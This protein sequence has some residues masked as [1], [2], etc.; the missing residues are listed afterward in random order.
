[1]FLG[2]IEW[3]QLSLPFLSSNVTLDRKVFQSNRSFVLQRSK[4]LNFTFA[5]DK[6][7]AKAKNPPHM[8]IFQVRSNYLKQSARRAASPTTFGGSAEQY[9]FSFAICILHG[10]RIKIFYFIGKHFPI[11]QKSAPTK[12]GARKMHNSVCCHTNSLTLR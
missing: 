8:R 7:F 10:N 3:I 6:N 2:V 11:K 1:M 12:A 4:N 9:R 5:K